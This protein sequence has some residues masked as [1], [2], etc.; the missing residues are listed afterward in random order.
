MPEAT[1]VANFAPTVVSAELSAV[2]SAALLWNATL[3]GFE[4]DYEHYPQ[5]GDLRTIGHYNYDTGLSTGNSYDQQ[6][7]TSNRDAFS[8]DLTWFVDDAVGSHELK[9]GLEYQDVKVSVAS[10]RTGTPNGERCIPGG[11]GFFFDDIEHDGETLPWLMWEYWTSGENQFTGAVSTAFLQDAWRITSD[12]TL[13]AGVRYDSVRYDINTGAQVADMGVV[14]PRIGIA[15]DVSGGATNVVRGSWGRFMHPGGLSIPWLAAAVNE[16]WNIWY[17]CSGVLPLYFGMPV[18]SAEECAAAAAD[19]GWDYRLDNA[20]WD[21]YGW[22]LAPS[23]H[24]SSEPTRVA[25]GLSATSADE[26]ILAFERQFAGR[27]SIELSF[28]DKTTRGMVD[29]TCNGNWPVPT[30]GAPC[31]YYLLVNIP[32]AERDY[33][34]FMVRLETRSLDWLTLLASY[35][36]SE[37]KGNIEYTQNYGS[38]FDVYPW[39]FDNRYGYLSDHRE[40]RIKLNGYVTLDGDWTI[41]FDGFWSSAFTWTPY[42]DESDNPAIPYGWHFLEPR[43]SRGANDQYQLDLQL[44][45]GFTVGAVRLALIGSAFNV[46]SAEQPT[47]VC[48]HVSGCG[49]GEGGD[50]I[51]MGDPTDWQTPRRYE[52]GFRVEF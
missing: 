28:V 16:P 52:L 29:D 20:G 10:C 37:S 5:S 27:S 41:A 43:G 39:H 33:R 13:K 36:W 44:T 26:L 17:S 15:W 46:F 35:T 38:D 24:Y 7:W 1:V 45:K 32:D 47:A 50:P 42:E 12:L 21:P 22:V 34:A 6:Y 14:Q 25:P 49:V 18:G 8:T 30:A 19:L 48:E 3:G 31:D 51:V 4:F 23:E 40:H 2:L 11:V 9:G